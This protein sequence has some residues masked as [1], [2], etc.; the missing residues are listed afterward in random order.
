MTQENLGPFDYIIVG[1]GSAGCV[2]ANRLSADDSVR[3]CLVEAGDSDW[4]PW[5]HVPIGYFYTINNPR[6]DWCYVA[7]P[8]A[9]LSNRAIKYPRGRVLGGSSS[10]NAM[11]Y[12]RGQAA[13]FDG[14]A[15]QGNT[16]WDWNSVL[17]YFKKSEDHFQGP[18]KAHGVGGEIR[19]E[20]LRASWEVLDAF[21]D[22]AVECGIPRTADFNTGDNEGVGYFQVTQRNGVRMSTAR[23]FLKPARKRSN[24]TVLT[25]TQVLRV[26]VQDKVATGLVVKRR[27]QEMVLTSKREVILSAGAVGSPQ[28][29]MLSGIGDANDLQ[30]H[31]IDSVQHLP[32]VG[33]NLQDH[34]AIR[35]MLRIK[36][37]VTLNQQAS[38]LFG[39]M[40]MGLDYI[41]RRRGPL[42]IPPALVNAFVRSDPT[43]PTPDLQFVCYP[44]TYDK[45]GDPPHAF[46]GF[47]AG[48]C[49][50]HPESRGSIRLKSAD[51]LMPPAIHL[52]F[53][54]TENDR[55]VAV[56]GL[57]ALRK[58][59]NSQA[60]QRF[61]PV[62]FLPG[63][64]IQDDATLLNG[65]QKMAGTIFH[66]V[67][68]CKMGS[69]AESVV[70]ARLRVHGIKGLRVVDASIMPKIISGNTNATAIMIGEKAS[71]MIFEDAK[72][73]A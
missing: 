64:E 60:M 65:I 11:V 14:W 25:N 71:D 41:F 54:D 44:I 42:T 73:N 1:A 37:T 21:C 7:E 66:P 8:D 68:T 33:R 51:P 10:I 72:A 53:L 15:A 28:I 63:H 34:I 16:G 52:N 19:V 24:L 46:P 62:E 36:D 39:R 59:C 61:S 29:L 35:T 26:T 9:N 27:G 67:G 31:G 32:G 20:G 70:D 12:I 50:L 47:T 57:R 45:L 49:V 13:D 4:Y 58:V 69:D 23:A 38:S 43:Q 30:T 18:S 48:V 5:I 2:L 56:A 6:T 3:V 55:R 22:A 40:K 17:P